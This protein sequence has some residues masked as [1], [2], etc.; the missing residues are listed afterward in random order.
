MFPYFLS[1]TI[2]F[3]QCQNVKKAK[4]FE[5]RKISRRLKQALDANATKEEAR[6]YGDVEKIKEQLAS[7]KVWILS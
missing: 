5:I 6:R 4:N 7:V 2:I 3:F 1:N